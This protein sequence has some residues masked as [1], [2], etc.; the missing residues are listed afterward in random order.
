MHFIF[1]CHD[2]AEVSRISPIVR[3]ADCV[4]FT[5]DTSWIYSEES[6]K[7]STLNDPSMGVFSYAARNF[8]TFAFFVLLF[9]YSLTA[10]SKK[11]IQNIC[12]KRQRRGRAKD[13]EGGINAG[14]CESK[15][16]A[17]T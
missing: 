9:V 6:L 12:H 4:Q 10:T 7:Y 8:E 13:N 1:F 15:H 14:I 11:L 16:V 3:C 17:I 5:V 2:V